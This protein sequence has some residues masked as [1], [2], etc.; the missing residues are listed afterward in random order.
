[1][2]LSDAIK[3]TKD[4]FAPNSRAKLREDDVIEHFQEIFSPKNLDKLTWDKFEPVFDERRNFHWS[5]L[6]QA[7]HYFNKS[8]DALIPA[9]KVLLDETIDITQRLKLTIPSGAKYKVKGS[10][11][12][13]YTPILMFVYPTKYAVFNDPV[14]K[15][16]NKLI[17]EGSLDLGVSSVGNYNFV[18][19]YE[20]FNKFAL[21]LAKDNGLT[22]WELDW[23]WAFYMNPDFKPALKFDDQP[24]YNPIRELK[25]KEGLSEPQYFVPDLNLPLNI[26]LYGPVGTGKTV[27]ANAIAR[28]IVDGKIQ[29]FNQIEELIDDSDKYHDLFEQGEVIEN[30]RM[31]TFH[32][33]YGYEQF[34]EGIKPVKKADGSLA[35]DYSHGI[36]NEMCSKAKEAL[37]NNKKQKF[38]LIIDEINRGDIS[39][40]FGELITLIEE[41]KRYYNETMGG[42]LVTLPYTNEKFVVPGNLYIIG[43][44][45]TTDKSI[46]L[47]DLALRRRF[48]FVEIPPNESKLTKE[49]GR[50]GI[51]NK[52]KS[53]IIKLFSYI[54]TQ[55]SL[56]GKDDYRIGQ[57]Y[58]LNISVDTDLLRRWKYKILP[59]LEEY[60]YDD[61]KSLL[62]ILEKLFNAGSETWNQNKKLKDYMVFKNADAFV[63]S[64]L[65]EQVNAQQEDNK[66]TE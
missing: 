65:G 30:I 10:G 62:P 14:S 53:A 29:N 1:M 61:E 63:K 39:R 17:A 24:Y 5:G 46:A 59:L 3:K 35:Y 26:I 47:I 4:F 15:A 55:L 50:A 37:K 48:F 27:I 25:A 41:D 9:L 21:K 32:K 44:M 54:N 33:S 51:N 13:I 23:M 38:V 8:V 56:D 45:N 28:G 18:E 60:Y 43:T 7:K 22:L 31:V 57:A 6:G 52:L 42:M 40:I 64:V 36:F 49:L 2:I 34:V 16:I 66:G 11:Q 58:F 20:K 19:I 12:G